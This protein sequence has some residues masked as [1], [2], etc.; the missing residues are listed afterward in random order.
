MLCSGTFESQVFSYRVLFH[1][2][3]S[4]WTKRM[5]QPRFDGLKPKVR[6]A[7]RLQDGRSTRNSRRVQLCGART[8]YF[9]VWRDLWWFGSH[10]KTGTLL[11]VLI[12]SQKKQSYVRHWDVIFRNISMHSLIQFYITFYLINIMDTKHS[13]FLFKL[14]PQ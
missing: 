10:S 11:L 3:V 13:I 6:A 12:L 14:G 4:E 9:R 7:L 5:G 1:E 2:F 8:L